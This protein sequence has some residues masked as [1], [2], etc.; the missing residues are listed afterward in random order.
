[1]TSCSFFFV[2]AFIT[3]FCETVCVA[4]ACWHLLKRDVLVGCWHFPID[5]MML[6]HFY[7]GWCVI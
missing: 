2:L 4:Y 1:L 5:V 7:W 6:W 3:V